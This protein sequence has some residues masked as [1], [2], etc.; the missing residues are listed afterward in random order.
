MFKVLSLLLMSFAVSTANCVPVVQKDIIITN[1]KEVMICDQQKFT[2]N[3]LIVFQNHVSNSTNQT[4]QDCE[5]LVHLIQHQMSVANQ[6]L[7]DI[8]AVVK[9]VCQRLHS[10][11]GKECLIV[12]EDVQQI[13]NWIM[14][15]LSFRQICQ[16]LGFCS[17]QEEGQYLIRNSSVN[18]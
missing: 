2:N 8:I 11:S 1:Q 9:D 7:S 5:F 12:I 16:K 10:P 18:Y 4:C 3:D 13:I 14:N 17:I 15:G 6:T